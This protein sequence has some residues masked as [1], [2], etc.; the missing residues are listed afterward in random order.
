MRTLIYAIILSVTAS[1]AQAVNHPEQ[2]LL[3][4]SDLAGFGVK[5]DLARQ[6][7]GSTQVTVTVRPKQKG[8]VL[9]SLSYVVREKE[10]SPS[11]S[12]KE[13]H[14]RFSIL[15]GKM[16][17]G[18]GGGRDEVKAGSLSFRVSE[19]EMPRAQLAFAFD[20]PSRNDGDSYSGQ[21][22]FLFRELPK[23]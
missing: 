8:Y 10:L 16:A 20:L 2:L 19:A 1:I 4:R 18:G 23:G 13:P 7:D 6:S 3:S 17:R 12:S 14:T 15:G 11:I 21:Y 9:T 5:I 22:V